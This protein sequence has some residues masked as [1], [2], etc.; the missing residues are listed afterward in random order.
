METTVVVLVLIQVVIAAVLVLF[1]PIS[2]ET[3][4]V[5]PETIVALSSGI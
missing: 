4:S 5:E 2:H 1:L 3:E